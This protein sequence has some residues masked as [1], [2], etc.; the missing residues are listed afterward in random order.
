MDRDREREN[1]EDETSPSRTDAAS[2]MLKIVARYAMIGFA[3]V[4]SVVALIVGIIALNNHQSQADI[5][6]LNELTSMIAGLNTSLSATKGEL[7]N[8][9]FT[10]S[11]EKAMRGEE[12][13][14]LDDRIVT[15][16]ENITRLQIKLKVA[17][18]LEVQL[19]EA[20]S[21]PAAVS[22]VAN[23]V[24]ALVAVP[25]VEIEPVVNT[26]HPASPPGKP[27]STPPKPKS[28]KQVS[29]K[30]PDQVKALK[31]TIEQFNKQ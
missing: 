18:T 31:Q 21:S 2:R 15:I 24:P 1:E 7:E 22:P 9:K 3:P 30:S 10:L 17:P 23:T 28:Q 8:L 25:P 13:K 4:V 14:K 5:A 19:R 12:R 29:D 27:V 11:R 6:K 20:A 26:P 16:V